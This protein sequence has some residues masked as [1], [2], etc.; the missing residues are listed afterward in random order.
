VIVADAEAALVEAGLA[1]R[2]LLGEGEGADG[3]TACGS[4]EVSGEGV[5]TAADPTSPVFAGVPVL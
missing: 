5:P 4:G 1:G 3:A 2:S